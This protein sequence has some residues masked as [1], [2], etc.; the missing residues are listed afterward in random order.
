MVRS[1]KE[2][3]IIKSSAFVDTGTMPLEYTGYGSDQ[4]PP[5]TLQ[6]ISSDARSIAIIMEDLDI[7]MIKAFPHWLIW[8]IPVMSDIPENIPSGKIVD[9]LHGAIQG[10]AYGKHEYRGPKPPKII[11]NSHR[12]RFN[13]YILDA[14]LDLSS[15]AKKKKLLD[16]MVGH[17]L[18]ESSITGIFKNQ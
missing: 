14:M 18:Q 11:K 2:N 17:I 13:V 1:K 7:P 8:N 6:N 10:I 15:D 5:L 12:Y 3:L 9:S 16:A 4:S